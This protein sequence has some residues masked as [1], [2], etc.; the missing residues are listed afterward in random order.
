[1]KKLES[2]FCHLL[3]LG[4]LVGLRV[5]YCA[6]FG[7]GATPTPN[8]DHSSL[9]H[10]QSPIN[11]NRPL[12]TNNA[13]LG[14]STTKIAPVRSPATVHPK[15]NSEERSL[16]EKG[17]SDAAVRKTS[18]QSE[19]SRPSTCPTG[20]LLAFLGAVT[21]FL[22]YSFLPNVKSWFSR[23]AILPTVWGVT[24]LVALF[25]WEMA[26]ESHRCQGALEYEGTF[27]TAK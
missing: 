12:S 18:P 27:T 10:D 4:V 11:D 8:L 9:Y 21:F 16:Y 3:P 24:F 7:S 23:I 5:G 14:S 13:F 20:G 1:M 19:S 15:Q 17:R 2:V 6:L 26:N 25:C 22:S